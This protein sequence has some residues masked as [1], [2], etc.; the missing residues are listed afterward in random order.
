MGKAVD[1]LHAI[2]RGRRICCVAFSFFRRRFCWR[3]FPLGGSA[4]AADLPLPEEMQSSP[5]PTT[6]DLPAVSA[7]NGK[8]AVF[9]GG[10]NSNAGDGA[11]AGGMGSFSLPVGERFGLQGD[12]FAE[13]GIRRTGGGRRRASLLARSVG[14]T[15]RR[16]W[17]R[18]GQRA[19]RFQLR[20][21]R[22]RGRSLFGRISFEGLL[23]WE[24][25]DFDVGGDNDEVFALADIA[26]YATDDFRISAGCRHPGTT[27]T[28]RPSARIG[29]SCRCNGAGTSAALFAEGRIGEDSYKAIWGGLRFYFGPSRSR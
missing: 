8:A 25:M 19:C 27:S 3:V 15:A 24:H 22:H 11:L 9:G 16:L 4:S 1:R 13:F 7:P 5:A 10:I 6:L 29:P 12:A 21:R 28:W 23:G 20:A 26:F 17:R 2:K 18:C 14:R